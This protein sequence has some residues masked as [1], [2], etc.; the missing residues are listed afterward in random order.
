MTRKFIATVLGVAVAITAFGNAPAR[1]NEDLARALAAIVGVAI[2]GKVISDS[3]DDDDDDKVTRPRYDNRFGYGPQHSQSRTNTVR[4]FETRPLPRRADRRL[5][6]G[7]C[8]RSFET[9]N[10][11][12]RVFGKSCL[13]KNYGFT[14]SLP[15]FCEVKFKAYKKNRRG[16]DARCLRRQGYQ[17]ARR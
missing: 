6:P 16:Y 14:R 7:D 13:E 4:R 11:R 10:G 8:L 15:R 9:R 12:Y 3:L 1:A 2:V 5:L 17:L